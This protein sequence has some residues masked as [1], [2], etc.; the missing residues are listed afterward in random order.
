MEK[1]LHEVADFQEPLILDATIDP[2]TEHVNQS[3]SSNQSSHPPT[4]ADLS[5]S[6][7]FF[8]PPFETIVII[9]AQS[10]SDNPH[11]PNLTSITLPNDPI[12]LLKKP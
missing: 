6:A 9:H 2:L 7:N 12:T 8:S 11:D 3:S 4:S 1:R 5:V 10:P